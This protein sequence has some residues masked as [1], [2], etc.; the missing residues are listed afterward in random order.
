MFVGAGSFLTAGGDS[1][2]DWN[3]TY[4][5]GGVG[6]DAGTTWIQAA[7]LKA[8][9]FARDFRGFFAF[10]AADLSLSLPAP[11]TSNNAQAKGF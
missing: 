1:S 4:S 2:G 5:A 11:A 8:K 6:C 10:F 3:L 9:T 7:K